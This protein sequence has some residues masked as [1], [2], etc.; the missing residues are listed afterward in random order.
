MNRIK[1]LKSIYAFLFILAFLLTAMITL[2]SSI[3][4]VKDS[5]GKDIRYKII[6]ESSDDDFSRCGLRIELLEPVDQKTLKKIAMQLRSNRQH[7]SYLW[8]WYYIK[9]LNTDKWVWAHSHFKPDG[10]ELKISRSPL[11]KINKLQKTTVKKNYDQIIGKWF[12]DTPGKESI[13]TIYVENGRSFALINY[14]EGNYELE[15]LKKTEYRG[16]TKYDIIE[17]KSI[18]YFIIEENGNLGVYGYKDK[19]RQDKPLP[20]MKLGPS[21]TTTGAPGPGYSE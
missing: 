1:N 18:K 9:G 14:I 11:F 21:S 13:T 16:K 12:D 2:A 17:G 19:F 6:S 20:L 10:L 5:Q 3:Y 15:K 7:F 4:L 8:I